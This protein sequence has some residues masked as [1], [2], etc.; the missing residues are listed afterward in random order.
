VVIYSYR[1]HE[2]PVRKGI[3][4]GLKWLRI[5]VGHALKESNLCDV[6]ALAGLYEFAEWYTTGP[7]KKIP[8]FIEDARYAVDMYRESAL[9]GY[10]P[11]QFKLGE[12][13]TDGLLGLKQDKTLALY[14]Y[15]QVL[16]NNYSGEDGFVDLYQWQEMAQLGVEAIRTGRAPQ[17][18]LSRLRSS[19]LNDSME[20]RRSLME[21]SKMLDSDSSRPFQI[22]SKRNGSTTSLTSST[23]Q[24]NDS[25]INLA[26][27]KVNTSTTSLAAS[28]VQT[29]N[30]STS[31]VS[32]FM[33]LTPSDI[34]SIRSVSQH[35]SVT[36]IVSD[37]P[38]LL[39]KLP[40]FLN[41]RE[42]DNH[43]VQPTLES[44]HRVTERTIERPFCCRE[45]QEVSRKES[46]RQEA[47]A[48]LQLHESDFAL[49]PP[50]I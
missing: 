26:V 5:L 30:S 12:A 46:F 15:N 3:V 4:E 19:V 34:S 29:N 40:L 2:F 6:Y 28:S 44:Y 22:G 38:T 7:P 47:R 37:H 39:Q 45:E 36:N 32:A 41:Q 50:L 25:S 48:L 9:R 14:W 24:M 8:G 13:Y 16:G 27:P 18:R 49:P 10:A 20:R 33:Q 42:K 43:T 11:A 35:G 31:L 23:K 1:C 21:N 17:S